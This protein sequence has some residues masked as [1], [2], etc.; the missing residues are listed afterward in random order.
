MNS[1]KDHFLDKNITYYLNKW[2][3]IALSTEPVNLIITKDLIEQLYKLIK[4]KKCK[5]N[6]YDYSLITHPIPKQNL[7][8]D[9]PFEAFPIILDIFYKQKEGIIQASI[10]KRVYNLL[11][12]QLKFGDL[13]ASRIKVFMG[14]ESKLNKSFYEPFKK[15]LEELACKHPESDSVYLSVYHFFNNQYF[16]WSSLCCWIDFC[17]SELNCIYPEK[18]WLLFQAMAK[19]SGWIFLFEDTAIIC[20]RPTKIIKDS[21]NYWPIWNLES[22]FKNR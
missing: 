8:V 14:L 11:D 17:I 19:Q 10:L 5:V 22:E 13:S 20:Q 16:L 4:L 9:T 21:Q 7:I 18:E 15:I 3:E 6:S 12:K 1:K 2:E